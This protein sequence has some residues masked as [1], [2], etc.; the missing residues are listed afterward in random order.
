MTRPP[1]QSLF[2]GF[3]VA[4]VALHALTIWE[5]DKARGRAQWAEMALID[6]TLQANA[7]REIRDYQAGRMR[8]LETILR[9]TRNRLN[10]RDAQHDAEIIG[11]AIRGAEYFNTTTGQYAQAVRD[12]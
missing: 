7:L 1:L 12:E 4:T 5:L 3:L 6:K 8:A 10:L 9:S 2:L 11:I